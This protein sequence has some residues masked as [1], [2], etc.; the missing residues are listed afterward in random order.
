MF[1]EHS[2][3]GSEHEDDDLG[4]DSEPQKLRRNVFVIST[5][6]WK[7][8]MHRLDKKAM[9]KRGE[10]SINMTAQRGRKGV[11]SSCPANYPLSQHTKNCRS[12][13]I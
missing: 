9:R 7:S 6:P 1:S 11:V 10:K 13:R 4:P 5:L 2:E 3:S 8:V 12:R